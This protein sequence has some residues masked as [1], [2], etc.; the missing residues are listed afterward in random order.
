MATLLAA[1]MSI[2]IFYISHCIRKK[3]RTSNEASRHKDPSGSNMTPNTSGINLDATHSL[4]GP[5]HPVLVD[6][7]FK[8]L[9]FQVPGDGSG[10][11]IIRHQYRDILPHI[12]GRIP[13]GK[14]SVV[15]GPTAW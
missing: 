12:S 11:D 4:N 10:E 13:A 2:A 3:Q 14:F 1:L 9:F 7:Q 6:V 5:R 15:L 8:N